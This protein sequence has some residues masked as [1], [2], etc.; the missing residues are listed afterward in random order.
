M[1]GNRDGVGRV[2]SARLDKADL[3]ADALSHAARTTFFIFNDHLFAIMMVMVAAAEGVCD[4]IGSTLEAPAE[5]VIFTLVVVVTHVVAA[6]LV[7]LDVF[8]FDLDFLGRSA[9]LV[10]D[11][12]S[13]VGAAAV[14]TLSYVELGLESLVSR[15]SAI[16]VDVDS[17]VVSATTA[18][19]VDVDLG[20]FVLTRLVVAF[21]RELYFRVTIVAVTIALFVDSNV[22]FAAGAARGVDVDFFLGVPSI[23][24]S[25]A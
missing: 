9:T 1:A 16:D 20:V 24:P 6:G 4:T 5:G 3:L 14:V 10:L 15:L 25:G 21:S 22:V 23:F 13:R 8:F 19:D 17:L 11:V 7:D 18:F 2:A 12:V